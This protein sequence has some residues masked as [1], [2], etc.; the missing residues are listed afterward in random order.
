MKKFISKI[1]LFLLTV[2]FLTSPLE[3]YA[4]G[5]RNECITPAKVEL[6][7]N[8]R[9]LWMDHVLWT[10]N[11]IISDLAD[12]GDKDTVINRLL[13]NQEDIGNAIKPYYGDEAGK[14]LTDLLKEH[15]VI[16]GKLVDAVKVTDSANIEKYNKEW[17]KN[18]DDMINYINSLN[19]SLT[20]DGLKDLFYTHLKVTTDEVLARANKDW[21]KDIEAYDKGEEH[22]IHLADALTEGIINQ[23]LKKFK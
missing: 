19:P 18:A 21:K 23:F 1:T 20:K 15:I 11:F 9:K 7:E 12:L 14:K 8:M 13:K 5:K 10:R 4:K 16:A 6:K 17:Y 3:T 2:M 22:I